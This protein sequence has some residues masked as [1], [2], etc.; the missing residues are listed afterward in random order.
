MASRTVKVIGAIVVVVVIIVAIAAVVVVMSDDDKGGK[1][2]Y[3]YE[4]EIV[5]SFYDG[6]FNETPSSGNQF[7]IVTFTVVNDSYEDGFDTNMTIFDVDLKVGSTTYPT[8]FYTFLHPGYLLTD[9]MVGETAS[10]VYVYEVPS[11]TTVSSISVE[12]SYIWTFDPPT[13]ERDRSLMSG[14]S[15]TTESD[16]QVRFNYTIE[17]VDSFKDGSLT[18]KPSSGNQFAILTFTVANDSYSDGFTTNMLIFDVDLEVGGTTYST[19]FYS[20]MH[21]G[22]L[23]TTIAV[24]ETA[25]FTYVYEVPSGTA[26]SDIEVVMDYIWTFDP[27]VMG[28]DLSL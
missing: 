19:S 2:R 24:G 21:P 11:G 12:M 9:I 16:V 8:S 5:D 26:V 13:M 18:E 7:A 15:S 22:Y 3:D 27:P 23:L 4:I 28:L 6:T 10:F 14:G 1:V 20:Y 17:L 25:T